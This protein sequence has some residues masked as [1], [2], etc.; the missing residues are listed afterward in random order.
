MLINISSGFCHNGQKNILANFFRIFQLCTWKITFS[1]LTSV[2]FSRIIFKL[3]KDI[4]C[5]KISDKLDHGGSA[6]LNMCIMDHLM[7]QP[8]LTFLNSF[9]KLK[10][11][12]FVHR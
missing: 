4:Y 7:S 6:S 9:F 11:P 5:P 3:G 1:A 10:S 2:K 8:L 12:N